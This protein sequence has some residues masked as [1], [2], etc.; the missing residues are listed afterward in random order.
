VLAEATIVGD[1][2]RLAR[3]IANLGV[4]KQSNNESVKTQDFG[5]N[6]NENHSDKQPGL[7]GSSSYTSIADDSNGETS[8]HARQTDGETGTELDKVGEKRRVLLETVRDQDR[9]DETVDTNDTS[10]DD[11]NDV[12]DAL[13][14]S[15]HTKSDPVM[16]IARAGSVRRTLD[17]QVRAE[18]THGRDTNAGFGSAIGG[19]EAGED[20]G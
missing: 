3:V 1:V 6:E 12:Y 2:D 18:Y 5:K 14:E 7:L 9:H 20:D 19:T 4:H 16:E 15:L 17:D 10:H 13:E 8:S 11:G